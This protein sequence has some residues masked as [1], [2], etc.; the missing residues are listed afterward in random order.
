MESDRNNCVDSKTLKDRMGLMGLKEDLDETSKQWECL[1]EQFEQVAM[2]TAERHRMQYLAYIE[3]GF[4]VEQA[5]G[6]IMQH[7]AAE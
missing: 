4:S 2:C 3:A 6:F 7:I 5:T 1:S